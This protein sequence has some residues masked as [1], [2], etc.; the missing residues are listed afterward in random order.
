MKDAQDIMMCTA[1]Q[2]RLESPPFRVGNRIYVHTD[3]IRTNRS[4]RKLA[5][6]KIGPF[7]I[8]SQPS[9]MSFTLRLPATICIHP[10]FH[11][12]QL[13]P[14][15][16]NTFQDHDQPPPPPLIVDGKPEYLIE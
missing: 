9:A 1:N 3:H 7:L 12:S 13:E 4:A 5:E 6:Q 14:E 8:V 15:D 2:R 10:I 11:I 16:P